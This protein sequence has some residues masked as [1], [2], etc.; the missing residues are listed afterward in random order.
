M[1]KQP[2]KRTSNRSPKL[3]KNQR[4]RSKSLLFE[5]LEA[6]YLLNIDFGD[7][8]L[9]YPVTEAENGA[10]HTEAGPTLGATR[11]TEVDGVHSDG[12]DS[13]GADEDGVTFGSTLRV[14][15]AGANVTVNVQSA[16]SG[17]RLDAWIDFNSDGSW[18]GAFEH[19]ANSLVVANGNNTVQFAVP[20]WAED[21]ATYARFRLSTAG[22]LGIKGL[23]SDGEVEDYRLT[24]APPG[25]STGTF[26]SQNVITNVLGAY[27]VFSTDIDGDGDNDLLSA[28]FDAS[29][30]SWHQNDGSGNF[31]QAWNSTTV[32]ADGARGVF[33]GDVD[34]DG[35]LDILAATDGTSHPT[36]EQ[37]SFVTWFPNTG[38][39][40]DT[41]GNIITTSIDK[42]YGVFSADLDGDG[43]TDVLSASRDDG[44]VAWYQNDG[45]GSFTMNTIS[46]SAPG[47]SSVF[48]ADVDSDGDMD[49]LSASLV[50]NKIAWYENNGSQ[51]FT[52]TTITTSA[53]EAVSVFAADVDGDGDTDVLSASMADSMVRWY[54]NNGSQTFT[55]R[56]VNS[57]AGAS[58]VFAT[59]VDGDG[60]TDVLS[61]SS[62]SNTIAWHENNGSQSFTAHTISSA[63]SGAAGVFGADLDG[64]GDIDVASA[65]VGDG[66]IAWYENTGGNKSPT[67]DAL[68][69]V[70]IDED[71]VQQTLVLGGISAGSGETQP[72]RVTATSSNAG[73]IPI[74][75][76]TYTSPQATGTATFTPVADASG[77]ANVTIT[78]EDG[79]A[80][81]DLST[82]A[83]NARFD[84]TLSVTVNP[85]NDPPTLNAL[86]NL[87][88]NAN[89][90]EQ[91]INLAGIDAGGAEAQPLRVTASSNNTG[92]IPNPAVVYTSPQATGTM[93]FTPIASASGSATVTVTV[94]DGGLDN[95][96]STAA[97][98]AT[99]SR[100]FDVAVSAAATTVTGLV[101]NGGSANRSGVA[102]LTFQFSEATTIGAAGS[103]ILWNHT[104]G[105]AVDVSGATLVN[106]GT[107]AVTWDL[108]S[109]GL[110]DGKYTATVP[111]SAASLAATHTKMLHVLPGDSDGD[112]SVGFG[113]FGELAGNFNASGGAPYI[114]G[115]M[116]GDGGVGF[117]DFGILASNF[118]RTLP[119]LDMDF[120]D[121]S[122]SGT[123]FRTTL[124]NEGARHVLGSGLLL[125]TTVDAEAD[126]QPNADATGDG[127]DEDGLTF[128]TLLA[129]TNAAITVTA[130]VP[131]T[132]VLN[133][134]IDF[135]A[136]GD[137][138]DAGEQIFVDEALTNGTNNLSAA[139]PTGAA[140]GQAFARFRTSSVAGY[141]HSGLA[142]DGEVEDY[143]VTVVRPSR[144]AGRPASI[145]VSEFWVGTVA[146]DSGRTNLSKAPAASVQP[147]WTEVVDLALGQ[148]EP[149]QQPTLA[150]RPPLETDRV[151]ELFDGATDL[152]D[153]GLADD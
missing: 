143:F 82:A 64:D 120:G 123:S 66:K 137:W 111:R 144:P 96:L 29:R 53:S 42:G 148:L 58:S 152:F 8:P 132:A 2:A 9:P 25:F 130:T 99:F 48:A 112:M 7:A 100:T 54:E 138:D 61:A 104:T 68:P 52:A 40:F 109:I 107:T 22:G 1:T 65:S 24:I 20:S 50:D 71:A 128:A 101:I 127:A 142:K 45:S 133:G 26:G 76:V 11:D 91:T 77:S 83:D 98:N 135:N 141:S 4:R 10:R 28:G 51:S 95:D 114:P 118:N 125:G 49:V 93:T 153:D 140:A 88:L 81:N 110:P 115:D 62:S 47:A 33:A 36:Q 23:A 87:A 134:W 57:V 94:E 46:T 3:T 86:T 136:D 116:D 97:D 146:E 145:G 80:D 89:A 85:V 75:A 13:D 39:T 30:V 18:G 92:L 60:D 74:P 151:D 129:G 63:A 139:I 124:A 43:D 131:G 70:T 103:L 41:G 106:N 113:D 90:P 67:L 15:Q 108:T 149:I 73:L 150:Q 44:R 126:G 14:G 16:P 69:N 35:D 119:A 31:S 34:G 21:G 78:V 147:T 102:N 105:S 27:G 55:A 5:S 117:G 17:A 32:R 19:I 72:L 6:R 12:A 56:T 79:G 37:D 84:R 121:A 122:E 38:T 59:D